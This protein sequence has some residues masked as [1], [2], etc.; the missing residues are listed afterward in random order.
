MDATI[1]IV[2]KWFTDKSTIGELVF[3]DFKCFT[4]EDTVRLNQPKVPSQ[5]AIPAGRYEVVISYSHRFGKLMPL[6]LDV[7]GF[8]GIRIHAGNKPD[9]TDGCLLVGK[10]YDPQVPDQITESRAAFAGVFARIM[11]AV[12]KGKVFISIG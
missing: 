4:L 10:S 11:D 1:N 7:P 3:D 8:E 6:L 9:Q 12:T 5:T 2:R